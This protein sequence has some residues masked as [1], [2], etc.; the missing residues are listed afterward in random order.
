MQE[1]R[2]GLPGSGQQLDEWRVAEMPPFRNLA[3]QQH[4]DAEWVHW[5]SPSS[6]C[7][8]PRTAAIPTRESFERNGF[9]VLNSMGYG[10]L[11]PERS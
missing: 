5:T 11:P 2:C 3:G 1:A 9:A 8:E 10:W 6:G 7:S 4:R